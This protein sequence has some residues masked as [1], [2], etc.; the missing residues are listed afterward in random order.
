VVE[1][2][3]SKTS[4]PLIVKLTPNTADVVAVAR[5][6]EA[7]GADAV[8]LINTLRGMAMHPA[9][10]GPWLGARTGGLSGPAVRAV[11]L[12]QVA[13]VA[14]AT[15]LPVVGMGGVANGKHAQDLLRAGATLVA[16][17][18]ESFR[19]PGAG[20]RVAR[21]LAALANPLENA[22]KVSSSLKKTQGEVEVEGNCQA[23]R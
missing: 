6:A 4:K 11:A 12:A 5:A 18:T 17:G 22:E 1:A 10:H 21:E 2:V 14:A 16:V 15:H 3:R 23:R 8:S 9:G 13:S 19:D 20:S 7:A